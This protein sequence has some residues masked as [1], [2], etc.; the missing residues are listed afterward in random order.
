M[1]FPA[2][3]LDM[4]GD[5]DC[6]FL[7]IYTPGLTGS[8]PVM[9]YIH[10][11]AFIG[12]SG[13]SWTYGPSYFMHENVVIVTINY[14]LGILGFLST[15]DAAAQGNY[16]LKDQAESFRWV[17]KNIAAF[18]GNPDDVTIFGESAGSASVNYQILSRGSTGVSEISKNN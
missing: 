18:G 12:G 11:G 7:N 1:Q 8:R 10:G 4:G 6:L 9:V 3:P 17:K 16:G 13:E 14:R 5:E 15:G 2:G